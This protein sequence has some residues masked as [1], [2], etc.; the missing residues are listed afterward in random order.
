V[1][2]TGI[3]ILKEQ[4]EIIFE[5]FRQAEIDYIKTSSGTGLGLTISKRLVELMGGKIRVESEAGKGSVFYF[6]IPYQPVKKIE[7]IRKPEPLDYNLEGKKILIVEDEL[8]SI[9]ILKAIMDE[10]Q[11]QISHAENGKEAIEICKADP[12]IDLVLMDIKMPVMNGYEAA[13]EIKK[14]RKDLPVIAQTAYAL[15]GDKQKCIQAGCDDYISKPID[16]EI[17]IKM[18][19]KYLRKK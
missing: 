15:K 18:M 6:T 3:G 16:L 12:D 5:R 1:K 2:D 8:S 7:E 14:I 10:I 9:Q 11:V 4:Q 17:L 13:R 19:N